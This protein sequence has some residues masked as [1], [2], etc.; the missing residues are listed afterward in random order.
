[1]K[2]WDVYDCP[3]FVESEDGCWVEYDDLNEHVAALT[4]QAQRDHALA[5]EWKAT[6]E[7]YHVDLQVALDR[8]ATANAD[9]E[10]LRVELK[11]T[12]Q[13]VLLQADAPALVRELAAARALLEEMREHIPQDRRPGSLFRRSGSHLAGQ[14]KV[15]LK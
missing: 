3:E 11:K 7:G 2:R 10:R 1:M 14:A 5:V 12:N 4:A 8:L 13:R 15:E 9:V 6:A